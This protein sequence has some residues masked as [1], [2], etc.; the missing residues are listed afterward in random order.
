MTFMPLEADEKSRHR[1]IRWVSL[2]GKPSLEKMTSE[3]TCLALVQSIVAGETP[4]LQ[5]LSFR[6][7]DSFQ[8]GQRRTRIAFWE[9]NF[10]R[11]RTSKGC[12]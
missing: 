6:D 4:D 7:P 5:D 1:E 11:V 2:A 12:P 9:K 10:G 8:S 3:N